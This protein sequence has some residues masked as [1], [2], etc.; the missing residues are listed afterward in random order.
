MILSYIVKN[1]SDLKFKLLEYGFNFDI[2]KKIDFQ[3]EEQREREIR[4]E[5]RRDNVILGSQ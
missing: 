5:K 4:R 3:R 1:F 2:I